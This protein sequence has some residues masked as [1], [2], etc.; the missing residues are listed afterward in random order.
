MITEKGLYQN[1]YS[2]DE[3]QERCI[4]VYQLHAAGRQVRAW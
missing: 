4:A 1:V 2:L 3:A